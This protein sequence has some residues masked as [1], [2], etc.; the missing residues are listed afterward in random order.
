M[1]G[2][3]VFS[4]LVDSSCL[5]GD[6]FGFGW[7]VE[8]QR[9]VRGVDPV[10]GYVHGAGLDELYHSLISIVPRVVFT[11]PHGNG[12]GRGERGA[13][14]RSSQIIQQIFSVFDA[15]A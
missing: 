6:V 10:E 9:R 12:K 2:I 11:M 5:G 13:T 3:S 8:L 7:V 14:N 15:Y 4:R 1:R